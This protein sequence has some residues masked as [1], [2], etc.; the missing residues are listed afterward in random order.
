MVDPVV[1]GAV[2]RLAAAA[3]QRSAAPVRVEG[4]TVEEWE[5]EVDERG[6]L[7]LNSAQGTPLTL[8]T[9]DQVAQISKFIERPESVALFQFMLIARLGIR[10]QEQFNDIIADYRETF[11]IQAEEFCSGKGY[12]WADLAEDLWDLVASHMESVFPNGKALSLISHDEIQRITAYV[13]S[14]EKIEGKDRPANVAFRE[15]VDILGDPARFSRARNSLGDIRSASE[16][17]YAELDLAHAISYSVE[18]F[19]F[20]Y[21]ALYVSRT[22]RVQNSEILRSDSFL[23][24]PTGRP[25]CV[26]V[27]NPGVGKSTMTQ[28]LVHQ[29]SKDS[30]SHDA[31]AAVVVSCKEVSNSDGGTYILGAISRSLKENLQ[32][33]VSEQSL[34]DLATLGRCFVIFDGIDEIIDI[35][36]R[37]RFVKVIE[38]FA[39]R[40]PLIPMLVTARR[41]GYGKAPFSS[42]EFSVYELDDFSD[43]QVAEYANNWFEATERSVVE[44]DAFLRETENVPDVRTNPLM[45]SL[46]CTLYRARGYIP[47]NRRE[48]YKSCADLLFQRWDAMRQIEQPVDHRQ[49]GTRL[50][51]ELALFFYKSQTAQAGVQEKQLGKIIAQFFTATASVDEMDASNRAQ[52]FLD[53]CADRAWLLTYQGTDDRD[54]RLFGFTHRTFM[55]YFAAEAIVRRSRSI[56]DIVGEITRA[57]EQDSSSVLADVIFQCADDKYDGGAREVVAG[58]MEKARGLGWKHASKYIPLC[59]RIMNAAPLPPA[60]TNLIFDAL[61]QHWSQSKPESDYVTAIAVFDLYRDPRNRC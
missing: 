18:N 29:L 48:V 19:R 6:G 31:Y 20:D 53:F 40:Y 10:E 55:E 3:V 27:G 15:I 33:D 51:Q 39:A 22:L 30:Q 52:D 44:R 25:R 17:H 58:L 24:V 23:T 60:S 38:A 57:Y 7:L 46:L 34:N 12:N 37:R 1:V 54:Q 26:V 14:T 2:S 42:R 49:Y 56:D 47:R 61:F 4:P 28:H 35:T 45:L 16:S 43:D 9:Q 32:L 8:L 5:E 59:L 50:M 11:A 21:G 36:R 13:G 41:V